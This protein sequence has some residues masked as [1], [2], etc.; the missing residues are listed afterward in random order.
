MIKGIIF[1]FDG[2]IVDSHGIINNLFVKLAEEYLGLHIT[3]EDFGRFP[4]MRFEERIHFFIKEKGLDISKKE[5]EAAK[6][7]GLFE[8]YTNKKKYVKLF[9]GLIELFKELKKNNIKIALGTNGSRNNVIEMLKDKNII[10]YFD[11]VVAYDDV[12]HGKPAPDMFL[13]NAENLGLE[14]SE[15]VVIEDS[16]E[17]VK[18]AKHAGMK[19]IAVSTTTPIS[20]LK[21]A[22]LIVETVKDLDVE[23]IQKLK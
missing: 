20:Q 18:A 11:S 5:I 6:E 2:V 7:K 15:C 22:D 4:G 19:V 23:K 3:E 8:Y 14:Q 17:G 10:Q 21:D 13:R 9:D 12:A 1:D 16:V